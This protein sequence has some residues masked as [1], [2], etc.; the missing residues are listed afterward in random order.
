MS[1]WLA[2]ILAG[3]AATPEQLTETDRRRIAGLGPLGPPP[4]DATNLAWNDATAARLGQRIFFDAGFSRNGEIS[5]AT[6][7]DPNLGFAAAKPLP[8][9]LSLGQR[10]TPS[11]LNVAHHR[12]FFWDG[13]AD[14][15]WAQAL[16]P[17][18][19]A[20]EFDTSRMEALH[21]IQRD[22]VL[23]M[24]YEQAFGPLPPP[25]NLDRFPEQAIPGPDESD[26]RVKAWNAMDE[27]DQVAVN[28]AFTN[29]GKAIAA[30]E[31][32]LVTPPS[33]FDRFVEAMLAE[34]EERMAHYPLSAR[35]G[36]MLFIGEAGCR[37]C[38]NGPLLSDREFH[39]IGIPPGH[40]GLPR[41]PGRWEG[42]T[43]LQANPFRANGDYSDAPESRRGQSTA[44]L[45]RNSEHW[46]AFRT[47]SLRNIE[48]TAPYMHHGQFE[49]IG[50]VLAYY[51]TLD[52]MVVLDHHQELVLQ[53]LNFTPGQL[54]DLEA[55]LRSLTSTPVDVSLRSA[56]PQPGP[57]SVESGLKPP[58]E[59]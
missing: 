59:P 40:D 20:E 43:K 45:V 28:R 55:F 21:R 50:E 8:M 13:R 18:E 37:Q 24:E 36:L 7:H 27:A 38:H 17:F 54:A 10:H 42:I 32:R 51:N 22:D 11:L 15:L 6:C 14:T 48:R 57:G 30:Y 2:V 35:R 31:H 25:E 16:H 44:S 39:N 47:P 53:P 9:G 52:D 4:A 34:D 26:P 23:R 41:D 33:P 46:G 19:R 3:L 56:P 5:C 29:L 1:I 12:W 49:T 58:T